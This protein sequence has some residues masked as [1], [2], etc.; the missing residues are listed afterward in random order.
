MNIVLDNASEVNI[1]MKTRKNL[2]IRI[3]KG[4]TCRKDSVEG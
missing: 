3:V 2:G 4:V 1:K